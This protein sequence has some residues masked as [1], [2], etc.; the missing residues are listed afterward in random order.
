MT[1]GDFD[2]RQFFPAHAF[3]LLR[4]IVSLRTGNAAQ[5]RT[6]RHH[7]NGILAKVM[8]RRCCLKKRRVIS[9]NRIENLCF[10]LLQTLRH[11]ESSAIQQDRFL[12]KPTAGFQDYRWIRAKLSKA[13]KWAPEECPMRIRFPGSMLRLADC[14]CTKAK[15]IATS[16]ACSNGLA[17][18]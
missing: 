2:H 7:R 9:K 3:R 6:D 16:P 15:A 14:F 18:G 17:A 8:I 10:S 4:K 12:P 5:G 11:I 13:T 1:E